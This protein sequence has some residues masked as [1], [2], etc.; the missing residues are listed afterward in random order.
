[1]KNLKI[2]VKM[3]LTVALLTVLTIVTITQIISISVRNMAEREA[4]EIARETAYHYAELLSKELE[5]P[6]N[7]ARAMADVLE[8]LSDYSGNLGIEKRTLANHI[9]KHYVEKNFNFVGIYACFE[10]ERFDGRDEFYINALGHDS[11][12]RFVP[13]WTRDKNDKGTINP[14]AYYDLVGF[15][16]FYRIPKETSQEAVI[17]PRWQQVQQ[18]QSFNVSLVVPVFRT[19][20]YREFI[21]VVGIDMDISDLYKKIERIQVYNT[22]YVTLYSSEGVVV[23]GVVQD[24]IGKAV[25]TISENSGLIDAMEGKSDEIFYTEDKSLINGKPSLVVGVPVE[26]GFTNTYWKATVTVPYDEIYAGVRKVNEAILVIGIIAIILMIG[27]TLLFTR[28]ILKPLLKVSD[29]L[30]KISE[31]EGDLTQALTVKGRDE[32]GKMASHFN[33]FIDKLRSIVDNIKQSTEKTMEVKNDLSAST[34]ETLSAI[35][36]ISANITSIKNQ[37]NNLDKDIID[38]SASVQQITMNIDSL[39]RQID[40]Q[41]SAVEESTASVNEMVASLGNVAEITK[42]KQQSTT[43]LV[44]SARRGGEKLDQTSSVIQDITANIDKIREMADIINSIASQTN[45]LS[46]NAAI[47]AAHAGE[48]GKGFSVVADEIRKLAETS[49]ENSMDISNILTD[50]VDKIESAYTFSKE[51]SI[52]FDEITSE[53][54]EVAHALDEI[55]AS[56]SE[57]SLGGKQIIDAMVMLNNISAKVR[58]GSDEMMTGSSGVSNSMDNVRRISGEVLNGINEVSQGASE[59]SSAMTD[60]AA[61]TQVLADNSDI[62]ASEVAKFKTS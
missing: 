20:G 44:Q 47:E 27:F 34:E 9:L 11:S 25:R 46:M 50:V 35:T 36:Q 5:A 28:L 40:E 7:E 30:I 21:G 53:I 57:L 26:I 45:L 14:V 1:M 19:T 60:V 8:S 13:H 42:K 62:L 29:M 38:S 49:A 56:A 43:K 3:V 59:I 55:S 58:E 2:G 54:D 15:N 10:P 12:G 24:H 4:H 61:I 37:I 31:G 51:T 32:I 18:G 16:S 17:E 39:G 48:Y 52:V 23:G 33:A 22:G 41:A 6:L